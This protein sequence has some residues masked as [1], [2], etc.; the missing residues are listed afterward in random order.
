M[1]L[2]GHTTSPTFVDWDKDGEMDLLLGAEDGHL[3]YLRR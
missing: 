3:Y 1:I 2:A